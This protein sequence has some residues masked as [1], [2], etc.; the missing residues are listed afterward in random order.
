MSEEPNDGI[1][2]IMRAVHRAEGDGDIGSVRA[3][4]ILMSLVSPTIR[5]SRLELIL[6][7]ETSIIASEDVAALLLTL[8]GDVRANTPNNLIEEAEKH[9]GS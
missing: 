1:D 8:Y 3:K 7:R 9:N 5:L 2:R 6:R 4:W